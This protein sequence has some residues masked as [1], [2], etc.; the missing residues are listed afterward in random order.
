MSAGFT[1][2]VPRAVWLGWLLLTSALA[3]L[4]PAR[5]QAADLEAVPRLPTPLAVAL[6]YHD[7]EREVFARAEG[8]TLGP[9]ELFA[10]ALVAGG[11][12]EPVERHA[13]EERF[14]RLA[15]RL[16]GGIR[17]AGDTASGAA[18]RA[19]LVHA[20]LHDAVLTGAYDLGC[21]RVSQALDHG[22]YNCVSAT[23]LFNAL[24]TE[25]GLEAAGGESSAHVVSVVQT[26]R[27][28]LHVETTCPRWLQPPDGEDTAAAAPRTAR[29]VGLGYRR[30]GVPQLVALVYYNLAVDLAERGRFAEAIAANY[31]ALRLDPANGNARANLLAAVNN[32]ALDLGQRGEYAAAIEL[33]AHGR[34]FAPTHPTFVINDAALHER[35]VRSLID[36][37][38]WAQAAS[39]LQRAAADHP[40]HAYFVTAWQ[41]IDRREPAP[42]TDASSRQDTGRD[43]L[44]E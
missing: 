6:A 18:E 19:A 21:S 33:L 32:W 34:H 14:R 41:Q 10:A 38:Q 39:V 3:A 8:G 1:T 37:G 44:T 30:V 20:F 43:A 7:A 42:P 27:G 22:R 24:A 9:A 23:I 16:Q 25:A 17:E 28:P 40:G 35:W 12:R 26:D 2:I 15:Q 36:Q 31:K 29:P 4:A 5:A 13:Y 11:V